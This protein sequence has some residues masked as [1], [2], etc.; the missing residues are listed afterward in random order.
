MSHQIGIRLSDE[1]F[2]TL[3]N[4]A[5]KSNMQV[6]TYIKEL[7]EKNA[8]KAV[9]I[10][11]LLASIQEE[12]LVVESMLSFMQLFDKEVYATLLGRTDKGELKGAEKELAV[13]NREF[14]KLVLERYQQTVGQLV[15]N[16][17]T[18]W[19][20]LEI[21]TTDKNPS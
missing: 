12:I 6:A 20:G 5:A 1:C 4:N 18:A 17:E 15:I 10:D 7:V 21:E 13:K 3:K 16:G 19:G 11:L 2:E 8:E 9:R 14:A